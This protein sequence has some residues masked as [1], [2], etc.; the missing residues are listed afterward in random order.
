MRIVRKFLHTLNER[1]F[2]A[3]AQKALRYVALRVG[4]PVEKRRLLL[5]NQVGAAF[6]STVKYGP[7]KG[8]MLDEDTR[9]SGADRPSMIFGFYELEVLDLID[10]VSKTKEFETFIDIGAAD[11]YYGVG[12]LVRSLFKRSYCFEIS[13]AGQEIIRKNAD[14]NGVSDRISIFGRATKEFYK[15][16]QCAHSSKS[17]VLVDIEGS[18]FDILDK[19]LFRAFQKS[20]FIIE[21]HEW[22]ENSAAKIRKLKED[23]IEFFSIGEIRTSARD[24]SKIVELKG[25]SDT[26]RW[27]MCSEGRPRL[28][29][30]CVLTPL[31]ANPTPPWT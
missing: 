9:W 23:A 22:V 4:D 1:G 8:L 15:L 24:L 30:W 18:E 13:D 16:I 31:M 10:R 27:L 3:A 28:M 5:S 14:I 2:R 19:E 17:L 25:Y 12:V 26:D 7:F 11:G 21:L 6:G 20:I 29:C